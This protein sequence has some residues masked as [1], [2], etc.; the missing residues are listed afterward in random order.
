[1]PSEL[2]YIVHHKIVFIKRETLKHEMIVVK[3]T[4][5]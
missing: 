4:Y 2:S 1:M 3:E 5:K